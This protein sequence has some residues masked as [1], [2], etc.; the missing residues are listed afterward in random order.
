MFDGWS[1]WGVICPDCEL[2][3][4]SSLVT[5][6]WSFGGECPSLQRVRGHG[7][8]MASWGLSGGSRMSPSGGVGG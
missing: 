8:D 4:R 5:L 2:V 1:I 3:L 7:R 6:A